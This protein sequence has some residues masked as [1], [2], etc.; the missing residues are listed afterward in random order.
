MTKAK[1][2]AATHAAEQRKR[3]PHGG[4]FIRDPKTGELECVEQTKSAGRPAKGKPA[5]EPESGAGQTEVS[6][7]HAG[8]TSGSTGDRTDNQDGAPGEPSTQANRE[9]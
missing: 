9:G 7:D 3:P 4:R 6:G 8:S 5:S 2:A 1:K